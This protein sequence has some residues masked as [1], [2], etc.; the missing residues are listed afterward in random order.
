[1]FKQLVRMRD[2]ALDS[3]AKVALRVAGS[4]VYTQSMRALAMPGLIAAGLIRKSREKAMADLLA[5]LNMPSRA[6]VLSLSQRLTHIELSLDDLA[7]SAA[8]PRVVTEPP[9][10][11]VRPRVA[12]EA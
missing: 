8:G 2:A 9:V 1:M 3:S 4:P 6:E 10:K 12:R 7:A 11:L 5:R